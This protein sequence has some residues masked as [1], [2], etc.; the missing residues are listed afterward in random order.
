MNMWGLTP[1][2]METL[3]KGF[4]EFLENVEEGDIKKEYLPSRNDRSSDQRR[5]SKK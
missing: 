5:Q 2:F 3:E 4:V 1:V